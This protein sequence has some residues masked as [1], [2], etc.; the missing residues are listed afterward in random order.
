VVTRTAGSEGGPGKRTDRK[1]STAPRLDPTWSW[2]VARGQVAAMHTDGLSC[3][4]RSGRGKAER[5]RLT[6]QAVAVAVQA[7]RVGRQ[8][9]DGAVHVVG[10]VP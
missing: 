5:L 7:E 3:R 6:A 1:A 4:G 10:S 8:N 9:P 2:S